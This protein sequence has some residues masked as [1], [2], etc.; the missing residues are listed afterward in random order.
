MHNLS[1]DSKNPVFC[2]NGFYFSIQVF[3]HENCYEIDKGAVST[4]G[5]NENFHLECA[6]LTWAGG[7][8][9][10]AGSVKLNAEKTSKGAIFHLQAEHGTENIRCVKLAFKGMDTGELAGLRM[11]ETE[12]RLK[13]IPPEGIILRYPNGFDGLYT[14]LLILKQAEDN[15]IY[16]RSMDDRVRPKTFTVLPSRDKL[17]V[18]LI[19][20]QSAKEFKN[21]IDVPSWEVGTSCDYE[22]IMKEQA[23]FIEKTYRL[24]PWEKREDIP[25]WAKNISLVASVHCQHWTGYKFNTYEQVLENLR[26]I[27]GR[28]DPERV[29]A[30]LPGWEG[31]YY[32]QY[33]DFRPDPRLGGEEGFDKLINEVLKMGMHI[34]PMFMING[35]NPRT[36]GFEEWGEPSI[37]R[38]AGGFL[39]IGGSC[40]WDSS[41]HYDHNCGILLNPGSPAWQDR[42]VGQ[43]NELID[44][45]AFDG[46]FMDLAAV[47]INDPRY[48]V[49]QAS[50]DIANRIR[51]DHPNVLM[52]GEGWYDAMSLSMPLTQPALVAPGDTLWSDQPYPPLF[53]KY[54]RCFGHLGTGDPSRGSTGAFEWGYNFKTQRVPLRKGILPTVTIVDG[55][56]K[57]APGKVEE[58]IEDAKQYAKAYL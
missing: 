22:Y 39:Q 10:A 17:D 20:E 35:A 15:Y 47:Y 24:K 38:T 23:V 5:T 34:M 6:G 16:F 30:Y 18:E 31:R 50:V 37:V 19:F 7:Q 13:K 28:I 56:I 55:T 57:N 58:I 8:E 2:F 3:T 48:D 45:Y 40:D 42:L 41:R 27:A 9:K 53:D 25:G 43:V 1:Y 54:N 36:Q 51:K 4:D 21:T 14:P 44:R 32:W 52:S 46:V 33:G 29:L 49:Y 26:W 11:P 12:D